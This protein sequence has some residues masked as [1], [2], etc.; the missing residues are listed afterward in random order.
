MDRHRLRN[1][2]PFR[3]KHTTCFFIA[4]WRSGAVLCYCHL[5][6][7]HA[8][9]PRRILRHRGGKSTY[10]DHI[11]FDHR[12]DLKHSHTQEYLNLDFHAQRTL[13]CAAYRH[14]T[15]IRLAPWW[16]RITRTRVLPRRHPFLRLGGW[17]SAHSHYRK[18]HIFD[19]LLSISGPLHTTAPDFAPLRHDQAS[20]FDHGFSVWIARRR[21]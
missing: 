21:L 17:A 16:R 9:D 4:F 5:N 20:Y 1:N 13:N 15:L 18:Q 14:F 3:P 7:E 2:K 11:H 8:L 19:V 10:M 6:S 12:I